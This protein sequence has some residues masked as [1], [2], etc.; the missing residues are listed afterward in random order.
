[1]K[2][3][4]CIVL[5]AVVA[6][7]GFFALVFWSISRS[8]DQS[9]LTEQVG[10]AVTSEPREVGQAP[11]RSWR[12]EYAYEVGGQWYGYDDGDISTD[13]FEPGNAIAVCVDPGDP[14]Q[15]VLLVTGACGEETINL[16]SIDEATPRP[17]P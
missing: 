2:A 15:H 17:A 10:A 4:G 1:M 14:A 11:T 3:V 13:Y 7:G 16:G 5:V 6:V 8:E 9:A 12:F